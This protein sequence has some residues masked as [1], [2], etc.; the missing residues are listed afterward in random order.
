MLMWLAS[1][2]LGLMRHVVL[3]GFPLLSSLLFDWWLPLL[4]SCKKFYFFN[5]DDMARILSI[6][7]ETVT[8][9]CRILP[10]KI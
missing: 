1:L 5:T 7:G 3:G 9:Y 10:V 2:S 4:F 6:R 8:R